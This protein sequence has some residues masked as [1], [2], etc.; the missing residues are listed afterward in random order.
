[1]ATNRISIRMDE[2]LRRDLRRYASVVRRPESEIVR[3]AL[4]EYLASRDRHQT[5]YDA[6]LQTGFIGCAKNAPRKLSTNRQYF[7]GFG[8]S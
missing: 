4:E 5:L 2:K 1:M 7:R 6:L 3:A 8:R